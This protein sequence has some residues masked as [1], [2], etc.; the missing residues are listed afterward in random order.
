MPGVVAMAAVPGV[1]VMGTLPPV[2]GVH[3]VPGGGG[4][5]RRKVLVMLLAVVHWRSPGAGR[6]LPTS[7]PDHLSSVDR[8]R[9]PGRVPA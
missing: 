9:L 8:H 5:R 3:L 1:R 7:M 2:I 4:G 6:I